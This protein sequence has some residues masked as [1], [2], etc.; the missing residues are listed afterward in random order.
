MTGAGLFAYR[1]WRTLFPLAAGWLGVRLHLCLV[2][3]IVDSVQGV[4]SFMRVIRLARGHAFVMCL[5]VAML[6]SPS[7]Q[8]SEGAFGVGVHSSM[9]A[10]D[11]QRSEL[12]IAAGLGFSS[13]RTDFQWKFAETAKGHLV[14]PASWDSFVDEA[15]KR[16]LKPI[17]ILDYGNSLYDGGDKPKSSE[18]IEAFSRYAAFVVSHYKGRVKVY[19]VWN[20]WDNTTG[21]FPAGTPEDYAKLFRASYVA[22]KNEDPGSVVLASSGVKS[23]WYERLAELGVIG[24]SDGVSVHPYTWHPVLAPELA[25]LSLLKLESALQAKSGRPVVDL[26]VTEIG[27]PTHFGLRGYDTARVADYAMRTPLVVS[28]LPFVKGVWWYDLVDDGND[29]LNVQHHFGLVEVDHHPKMA[30]ASIGPVSRI[31]QR[32]E[33]SLASETD[34]QTG[35]IV[36]VAKDKRTEAINALIAWNV[37]GARFDMGFRCAYGAA[38]RVQTSTDRGDLGGISANPMIVTAR[39]GKC[40][41]RKVGPKL[42]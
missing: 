19:E 12:D 9:K 5:L 30:S 41:I 24:E 39:E 22:I 14:I 38:P 20:E 37:G 34:L 6:L 25:A 29:W 26:Y 15:L 35:Q 7:S 4:V 27:W 11:A 16:G 23:G 17:L 3:W 32:Y 2:S 18:A 10:P 1:T 36:I 8:A 40:D 21:G 28:S 33:L 42:P 13:V 31:L